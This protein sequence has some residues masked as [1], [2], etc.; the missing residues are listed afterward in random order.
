MYNKQSIQRNN[1]QTYSLQ[2]RSQILF[3]W[4]VIAC[5]VQQKVEHSRYCTV[6]L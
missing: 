4:S 1:S 3:F 6:V 5:Q 2:I